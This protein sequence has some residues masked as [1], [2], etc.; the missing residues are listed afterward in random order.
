[1]WCRSVV[2][3]LPA[4]ALAAQAACTAQAPTGPGAGN[5]GSGGTGTG[6]SRPPAAGA[7]GTGGIGGSGGSGGSATGGSPGSGGSGG[8]AG[9]A[10]APT[11]PRDAGGANRDGGGRP[12]DAGGADGGPNSAG[13]G[14]TAP[15]PRDFQTPGIVVYWGQNGV[16]GRIVDPTKH[17]KPLADTCRDNPQ[18]EMI[19]IGF[20]ID[21]FSEENADRTP[22][23]NFSKHCTSANAFDPEHRRLYR[24]DEIGRGVNECQRLNKKVLI[25]LGGAVG[26]YGF[27]NDGEARTFAQTTWD[28]FLGGQSQYRPFSTAVLDG[29]DLDIESGGGT[30]YSAYVTRLRELMAT[31]KSRRWYVTAAPQCPFPDA[32]LG[33][34]AGK[35]FGDV[36]RQFDFLFV[37]FYNNFCGLFNPDFFVSSF[38]S[39]AGVGPKVMVGLPARADAGGGFVGRGTLPGVLNRVKSSPAFG[40]VMLWDASYDQN[41]DEGGALFSEFIQ[42]QLPR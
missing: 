30:G 3:L 5:G 41:S 25:S 7:P 4:L 22:R 32:H 24:C 40:G 21:F 2:R 26:G 11:P 28:L 39:W 29:V 16:G 19:V 42:T 13:V 20:V 31:D 12:A 37:Q 27:A 10:G 38:N 36:P 18:Y 34:G 33:P 23:V 6:G 17:E 9:T 1:M 8:A 14:P 35:A 15:P